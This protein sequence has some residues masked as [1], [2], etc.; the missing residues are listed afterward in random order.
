MGLARKGARAAGWKP[1]AIAAV[2]VAPVAPGRA[3]APPTPALGR[4]GGEAHLDLLA[5]V[6]P[7]GIVTHGRKNLAQP[8]LESGAA[9]GRVER[10][11]LQL[12]RPQD[13]HKRSGAFQHPLH[14]RAAARAGEV[15][16]VLALRQKREA[17]RLARRQSRQGEI[18]GPEGGAPARPVAVEAQDR[19]VGAAPQQ[20]QLVLSEG[21]AERRHSIGKTG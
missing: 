3:L 7:Q 10:P 5:V 16:R 1:R 19:L 2:A 11:G 4:E 17:Q 8:S 20:L 14:S 21:R 18:D 15:V 6:A 12:A 9:L 13:V